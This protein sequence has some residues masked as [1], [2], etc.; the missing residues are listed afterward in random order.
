MSFWLISCLRNCPCLYTRTT[1]KLLDLVHF[2]RKGICL[3]HWNAG[4]VYYS[5]RLLTWNPNWET[6]I[7]PG[8]EKEIR[9]GF[10]GSCEEQLQSPPAF[11]VSVQPFL[12]P[13]IFCCSLHPIPESFP[14]FPLPFRLCLPSTGGI[15]KINPFLWHF[16]C[17]LN[18]VWINLLLSSHHL[19]RNISP[20]TL[21][22]FLSKKCFLF[23]YFLF[24]FLRY[25]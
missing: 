2:L 4:F 19:R 6:G 25:A 12:L 1:T 15:S 8:I 13:H 11:P 10:W 21:V 24:N 3:I 7:I 5:C 23:V 16:V 20:N 9:I 17:L 14:A 18:R 22:L